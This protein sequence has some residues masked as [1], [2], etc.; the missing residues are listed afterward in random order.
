MNSDLEHRLR[1]SLRVSANRIDPSPD[2]GGRMVQLGHEVRRR[3]RTIVSLSAAALVAVLISGVVLFVSGPFGSVQPVTTTTPPSNSPS[4]RPSASASPSAEPV[5]STTPPVDVGPAPTANN[6]PTLA[7]TS[8]GV[9]CSI[10]PDPSCPVRYTLE[11]PRIF[12][13][14]GPTGT[15]EGGYVTAK[16]TL[17][18]SYPQ[19]GG[20]TVTYYF[21]FNGVADA[22]TTRAFPS[23]ASE[24]IG[25][26]PLPIPDGPLTVSV[27]STDPSPTSAQSTIQIACP[28]PPT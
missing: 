24:L 5:P 28:P 27:I 6:A 11:T 18:I 12:I 19:S 9:P 2:L 4:G 21:A 15:C 7:P 25:I 1:T 16:T 10:T 8:G 14:Y 26:R 3:R 13:T 23:G 20:A 17:F 22:A